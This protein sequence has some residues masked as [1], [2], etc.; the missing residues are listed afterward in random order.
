VREA[1]GLVEEED[2]FVEAEAALGDLDDATG[3]E[4]DHFVEEAVAGPGEAPAVLIWLK[5]GLGQGAM[6]VG[7]LGF[8]ATLGGEG[9]KAVM[10]KG[11]FQ[12]VLKKVG[13]KLA[14]EMPGEAGT[15]WGEHRLGAN[16]VLVSFAFSGETGVEVGGGFLGGKGTDR[17]GKLGVE[18][19][20]PVEWVHGE[21]VRGVEMCD[22]SD[23]VDAGIGSSRA[24]DADWFLGGLCRRFL[25]P[26]LDGVPGWLRLPAFEKSAVIGDGEFDPHGQ[27]KAELLFSNKE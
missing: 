24:V 19:G 5:G 3:E 12:W 16:V 17:G 20:N 4:T 6:V 13:I 23:G 9:F 11:G 18:R 15:K 27:G 1:G 10:A 21:V 8:I 14:R 22:L 26:I 7:G 2:K 25:K